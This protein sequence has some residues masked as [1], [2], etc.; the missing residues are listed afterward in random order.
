MSADNIAIEVDRITHHYGVRPVLRDV[1]LAVRRGEL[2]SVMG[3][4]GTG[5]STLLGLIAGVLWPLKGQVKVDGVARRSSAD[6]ERAIRRRVVY[7]PADAWL[8]SGT[9]REFLLATGRLYGI[10]DDRLVDHVDRLI[11][12]FHLSDVAD[13]TTLSYS[14]GQKRKTALAS[15]LVTE[16]PVMILDEPFGGGLDPSG[17]LALRHVLKRLA[18]SERTTIVMATPVPELVDG[19]AHRVALLH[20]AT[21]VA[22]DTPDALRRRAGLPDDASLNEAIEAITQ[23]DTLAHIEHYFQRPEGRAS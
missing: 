9:A 17:L 19:L 22:C 15:A 5:K 10:D 3:P 23:P 1:S 6:A 18:E 2:V 4:N 16:A 8:P 7:L 14:T 13:S 21:L 11:Q 12:L 20:D